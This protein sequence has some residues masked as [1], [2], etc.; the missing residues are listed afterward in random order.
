MNPGGAWAVLLAAAACEVGWA[1]ALK[2]AQ[3][4][5]RLF[6]AAMALILMVASVLLLERAMRE[7][8]VGTAYAVWTGLGAVGTALAG[9]YLFDEPRTAARLA[10]MALI[11]AGIVGLKLFGSAH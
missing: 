4:W 11:L 3:G 10:S 1:V 5:S 9:I 7:I 8:P 6:P 2:Y